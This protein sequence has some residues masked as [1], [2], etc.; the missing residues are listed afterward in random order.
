MIILSVELPNNAFAQGL[1]HGKTLGEV[2]KQPSGLHDNP[3]IDVGFGQDHIV[4]DSF[5]SR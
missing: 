5:L 2:R 4:I 3:W 1:L